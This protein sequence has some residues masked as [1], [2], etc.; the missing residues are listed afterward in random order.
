MQIKGNEFLKNV[1]KKQEREELEK[2]LQELKASN[3][4]SYIVEEPQTIT[5]QAPF[6]QQES[7]NP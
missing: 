7:T 3:E 2:R 4:N 5:Q 1:Q 6:M